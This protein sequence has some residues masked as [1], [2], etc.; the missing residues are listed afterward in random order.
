MRILLSRYM[1][2][3]KVFELFNHVDSCI[4]VGYEVF[5]SD[6]V[7]SSDLANDEFGVDVSFKAL[8]SDFVCKLYSD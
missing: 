7:L 6:I 1:V 5:M 3:V 4:M 2:D 8:D